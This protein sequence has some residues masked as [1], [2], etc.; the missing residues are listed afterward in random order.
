MNGRIIISAL[1]ASILA[2][3][4]MAED[5]PG[6]FK[7][8]GT[9]T[10]MKI[11]G[12][13]LLDASYDL[14][15]G[16]GGVSGNDVSHAVPD[17]FKPK[18]QWGTEVRGQVGFTTTTPSA[19]GD[20]TTKF[21]G[22]ATGSDGATFNMRHA[23]GQVGGLLVGLT[24]SLFIDGDSTY[25]TVDEGAL[26][27]D[28][29]GRVNQIRYT[30]AINKQ[31]SLALSFEQPKEGMGDV[32]AADYPAGGSDGN[33]D[34]VMANDSRENNKFP[35][36]I[37]AA[38]SYNDSWGHA[39]A[40]VAASRVSSFVSEADSWDG[41]QHTFSKSLVSYSVGGSFNIGNDNIGLNVIGGKSAYYVPGETVLIETPSSYK[42]VARSVFG[43]WTNYQHVWSDSI[44][45]N[46]VID[47]IKWKD[48]KDFDGD[49]ISDF[50]GNLD[51]RF[52]VYLNTFVKLTPTATFGAEYVY[53][54][55]TT[56]GSKGVDKIDGTTTD[57]V[58]ESRINMSMK[59]SFF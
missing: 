14:K 23:Y 58:K 44:K 26:L 56:K 36:S 28:T 8:P 48:N 46:I 16:N 57:S 25:S 41:A 32:T 5:A 7:V 49:P 12:F 43:G 37:V 9:E 42:Y 59:W 3:P 4:A 21:E 34:P 11:Y 33:G 45:S 1:A 55:V 30:F 50:N 18:N 51:K 31:A 2:I 6:Y 35:G 52:D 10:T 39:H 13:A 19:W 29:A 40:A 53:A 20:V 38:F 17:G 22:R 15:A 47:Y 27:A 24:D 54:K